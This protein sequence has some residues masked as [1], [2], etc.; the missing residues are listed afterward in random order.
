MNSSQVL[1]FD[2]IIERGRGSEFLLRL[3]S[4]PVALIHDE[5]EV[6]NWV[7][8]RLDSAE[9][10]ALLV[11]NYF[12]HEMPLLR[13]LPQLRSHGARMPVLFVCREEMAE[14]S[15]AAA[16]SAHDYCLPENMLGRIRSLIGHPV[17]LSVQ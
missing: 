2:P 3:A 9:F 17:P 14:C 5:E 16:Q 13:W 4:Y 15:L 6:F 7:I 11:V 8:S 1:L 10:P 12:H